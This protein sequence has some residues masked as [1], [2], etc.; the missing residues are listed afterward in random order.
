MQKPDALSAALNYLTFRARSC[1]EITDYL[2]K[3]GYTDHAVA[4]TVDALLEQGL[5]DD[6]ALGKLW[7]EEWQRLGKG[8]RRALSDRLR[9]L[10][11]EREVIDAC[12]A[13]LDDD[14]EHDNALEAAQGLAGKY[15]ALESYERDRKLSAALARRG[16][17]WD[18]IKAAVKRIYGDAAEWDE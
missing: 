13:G 12:L 8:S 14:Q 6:M 16:F 3:K 1:K 17:G 7:V 10:G 9:K 5:I 15:A 18:A 4:E 11:L 2:H